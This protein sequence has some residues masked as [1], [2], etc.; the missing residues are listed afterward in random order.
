MMFFR[1]IRKYPYNITMSFQINN[2]SLLT[3]GAIGIT[4]I[5]LAVIT[6]FDGESS[7]AGTDSADMLKSFMPSMSEASVPEESKQE[8]SVPEPSRQEEVIPEP[9]APEPSAPEPSAPEPSIQEPAIQE[10]S[11]QE[12]SKQEAVEPSAPPQPETN[13]M[14]GKKYRKSKKAHPSKASRKSKHRR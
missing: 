14:G 5:A 6:I 3:Y 4:S 7:P 11:K 9:S 12:E 1:R 10:E 2:L 13:T 8:E